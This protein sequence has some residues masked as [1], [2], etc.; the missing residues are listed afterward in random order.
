LR[1]TYISEALVPSR[2]TNSVQVMRMCDA[3]SEAGANVTLF[4]VAGRSNQA[5]EGFAGDVD[6]FYGIRGRFERRPMTLPAPFVRPIQGAPRGA[7]LAW[8][9]NALVRRGAPR[10]PDFW[11]YGR[12][13]IGAFTAVAA[14]RLWGRRSACRGVV[15]EMH[16]LPA[17]RSVWRVL[18]RV[19]GIVTISA[20]LRDRLVD[21][22]PTLGERIW[23]EHD[24]VDTSTIRPDLLD[25]QDARRRLSLQLDG[26]PLV[27]YTGRA[28]AGKGVDVLLEAAREVPQ[29]RFLVVGR[30]YEQEYRRGAP[31]NVS[32]TGFVPPA[33]IP[34]YL[35]AA[36]LLVMPTTDDLPYASY[37]S[38]LKLFEYLASGRPVVASDLP[39]LREVLSHESNALLY[40]PRDHAAL[41]AAIR[42][43]LSS[44]RLRTELA[45]Q[46]WS[47]VQPH[48]WNAR[49]GRLLQR[50]ESLDSTRRSG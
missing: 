45:H 38:P 31:T 3:F 34:P 48:S 41:A 23:V 18:D 49:A 4:H 33:T 2:S 8:F 5:P 26:A 36:D 10:Q 20:A 46:A 25:R 44:R 39:V 24:G 37:T 15:L 17:A 7:R 13:P 21:E 27:V 35:A 16:D 40:P 1:L 22:S 14:R 30:L 19:D 29:A 43:L 12:S 28:I 42:R 9:T 32:F 50:F 47:D 11:C 6:S